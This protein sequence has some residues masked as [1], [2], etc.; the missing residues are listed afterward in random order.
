MQLVTQ[1]GVSVAQAARDLGLNPNVLRKWVRE[2]AADPVH[3]LP[4]EG[5][6]KPE[7]AELTR[8]RREVAKL[9]MERDILKNRGLVRSGV[10]VKFGFVAK[11]RAIW[12]VELTC[13]ALGVSR[14]G[15]YAW[16]TRVPSARSVSDAVIGLEVRTSFLA[17]DRAYGA[18]R[19]WR[20]VVG[21]G[22]RCGLH[23]IERLMCA[24]A[25]RARPQRRARPVGYWQARY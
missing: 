12:P 2:Q 8:L 11:H 4:G 1:R 5:Q 9:K 23:R 6:Q 13:E 21:A 15:F 25:F 18:R 7:Q 14:S 20:D 16:L 17:S 3:A 19:V 24:Q 10:D 22:H